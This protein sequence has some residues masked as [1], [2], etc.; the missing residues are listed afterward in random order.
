MNSKKYTLLILFFLVAGLLVINHPLIGTDARVVQAQDEAESSGQVQILSGRI[1]ENTRDVYRLPGLQAGQTLYVRMENV[2]GNLD[3][4]VLLLEGDADIQLMTDEVNKE[5]RDSVNK[6]RDPLVTLPVILDEHALIW[7]DDFKD[8]SDAAFEFM[9]PEDGSYQLLSFGAFGTQSFGEYRLLVGLDESSLLD[10]AVFSTGDEIAVLDPSATEKQAT[11]K[12]ILGEITDANATNSYGLRDLKTGDTLYAY[13]E[14]TSGN[15]RPVLVL[16]SY[17]DKPLR[18]GNVSGE[19]SAANIWYQFDRDISDYSL[20]VE[21][22]E[23]DGEISAGEYRLL[24]GV[25]EPEV[26]NGEGESLGRSPLKEPIEV[27]VGTKLK[28]ITGIDQQS[29]KFTAVA[30]IRMEWQDPELAFNPDDCNCQFKTYIGD[31]FINYADAN[32]IL[33]PQF[34]IY[35][36]QGNR[37]LQNRNV[38][39]YPDGNAIY[40]ERFTTDLQAPLFDFTQ[41]PFDEQELYIQVLSL[42]TETLFKYSDP[43]ELSGIGGQLG[44][45]EWYVTSSDTSITQVNNRSSYWL[46]FIVNRQINF[47]ILRIFVPIVLVILVSWITFFLK[48]YGKRVDVATG[49]LLLFVAFNFTIS[50]ELPRL[51]Y[52]TF[53][54]AVLIGTFIVTVLVV[55]YNVI[56]RRLEVDGRSELAH[57]IDKPAI[58]V[59]P[60]LYAVGGLVAH[61]MFFT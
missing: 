49:N 6:G 41:F 12:E 44:E 34:T 36:Q 9:I 10:G 4:F 11:I 59:Y 22:Y 48:D 17:S 3:P 1:E 32:E 57:R 55:I 29:E 28:Q 31:T 52:L 46:S 7:N 21:S 40:L 19:D 56:L 60:L 13:V 27:S 51:G 61:Y 5:L 45:E 18:S 25:N 16:R 58:W 53:M 15:L 14:A 37:W 24:V 8:R 43:P 23:R 42:P 33:L 39:V 26:L 50:G 38:V 35:N 2:S 20:S 54:D 30:E 47:Y